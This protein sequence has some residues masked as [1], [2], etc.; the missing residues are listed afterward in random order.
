MRDYYS[1]AQSL[2]EYSQ[3]LRR[4]FHMH[5]ELGFQEIRTSKL[6]ANELR[7]LDFEVS[8]QVGKTGV[9]GILRG[10]HPGP[11]IMLRFD[12]DALPIFE[13][14]GAQYASQTPGI[15][16]ACGHDGHMAIG[17]TAARLLMSRRRELTGIVKFIFQPAEEGLGG[18]LAMIDDGV[19]ESPRP[20]FVLALHLWNSLPL[21]TIG[22]V[23]GPIMASSDAFLV[24]IE[25]KGGHA[26]VPHHT[27]DPLLAAAHIITALQSIVSRNLDPLDSAVVSA[28]AVK[29]SEAH[30][31]I[32]PYVELMGT[33]RAYESDVR[34]IVLERFHDVVDGISGSMGCFADIEVQFI[35]PPVN[36]HPVVAKIVQNVGERLF[37]GLTTDAVRVMVSEDAAYLLQDIPGCYFLVGSMNEE[38]GLKYGHHHPRFDFDEDALSIASA[39]M[40]ASTLEL[41]SDDK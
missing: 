26:A 27:R 29:S 39:V 35:T 34:A 24:R 12:M 37:P 23:E 15:M 17:L 1:E 40:V 3:L 14:T 8:T 31:V 41:L 9:V 2:F 30:N 21:G 25:G 28:T 36:N 19:L 13:E 20:D 33:I 4:E 11:T 10:M 22:V 6:I 16:H 18:A 5:P 38:K 7:N 32:A